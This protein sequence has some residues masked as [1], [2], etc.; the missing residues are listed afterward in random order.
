MFLKCAKSCPACDFVPY[1]PYGP[2]MPCGQYVTYLHSFF[3]CPTFLSSHMW[4]A[5]I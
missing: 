5:C 4:P 2:Y 3:N 1:F